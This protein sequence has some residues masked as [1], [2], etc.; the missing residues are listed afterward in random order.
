MIIVAKVIIADFHFLAQTNRG[1][2]YLYEIILSNSKKENYHQK[3]CTLLQPPTYLP[4]P[5][6]PTT[7]VE[8]R[9]TEVLSDLK[10]KGSIDKNLF[11]KLNR[12]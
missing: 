9:V 5:G 1:I 4:L 6:D 2:I 12:P 7:K 3:C 11:Y 10:K 8:R